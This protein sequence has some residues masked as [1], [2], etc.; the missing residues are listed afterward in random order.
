QRPRRRRQPRG[1]VGDGCR[2]GRR[3]GRRGPGHHRV[4]VG[5]RVAVVVR[6]GD[7]DWVVGGPAVGVRGPGGGTPPVPAGDVGGGEVGAGGVG[8]RGAGGRQP[9][10][11]G[12]GEGGKKGGCTGHDPPP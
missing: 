2:R 6:A 4:L 12:E 5:G 3:G 9:N 8:V 10:Q 11:A 7:D 1:R